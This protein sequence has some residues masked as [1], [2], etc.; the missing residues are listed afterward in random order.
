[1]SYHDCY[2]LEAVVIKKTQIEDMERFHRATTRELMQSLP[3]SV[4]YAYWSECNRWRLFL[5]LSSPY[6]CMPSVKS[7]MTICSISTY[8]S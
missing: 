5:T 4:P 1:M 6:C 2:G 3:K 8:T 7:Q